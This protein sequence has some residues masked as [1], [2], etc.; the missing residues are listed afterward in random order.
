M[1]VI[2]QTWISG[3]G[4]GLRTSFIVGL[5]REK[6]DTETQCAHSTI[7]HPNFQPDFPCRHRFPY[8]PI[9]SHTVPCHTRVY[10]DK[11]DSDVRRIL[12]AVDAKREAGFAESLA[13]PVACANMARTERCPQPT[14][15]RPATT[16]GCGR[17]KTSRGGRTRRGSAPLAREKGRSSTRGGGSSTRGGG[18][19]CGRAASEPLLLSVRSSARL[20]GAGGGGRASPVS[21]DDN[22]NTTG[23]PAAARSWRPGAPASRGATSSER[24]ETHTPRPMIAGSAAMVAGGRS[25]GRAEAPTAEAAAATGT[26]ETVL[27]GEGRLCGGDIS[28]SA[29]KKVLPHFLAIG[30]P[31]SQALV[32]KEGAEIVQR[33]VRSSHGEA[34]GAVRR[35]NPLPLR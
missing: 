15:E 6:G 26:S 17:A 2:E 28:P 20:S 33:Q 23:Q 29:A 8:R 32:A 34:T 13:G 9:P 30:N 4:A 7:F 31:G 10:Q 19:G 14:A 11:F 24:P 21:V 5:G 3:D 27:A 25:C 16:A 1:E 18:G 35:T 22:D 12:T